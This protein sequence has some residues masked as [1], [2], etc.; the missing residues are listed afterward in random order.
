MIDP[1]L[2]ERLPSEKTAI[3]FH[4][5]EARIDTATAV[6]HYK[7]ASE[8]VDQISREIPRNMKLNNALVLIKW[9]P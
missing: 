4:Y 9:A 8:L 7:T 2:V 6:G 5:A 3:R 1:V